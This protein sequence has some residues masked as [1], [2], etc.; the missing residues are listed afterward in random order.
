[1]VLNGWP[2]DSGTSKQAKY[3]DKPLSECE[4][5]C[6]DPN[7]TAPIADNIPRLITPALPGQVGKTIFKFS[8]AIQK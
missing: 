4:M 1:V 7:R 2:A 8:T 5:H 3:H 6:P